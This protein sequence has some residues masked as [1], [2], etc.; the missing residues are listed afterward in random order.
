MDQNTKTSRNNGYSVLVGKHTGLCKNEYAFTL[1]AR[2]DLINH[3]IRFLVLK[4]FCC[5]KSVFTPE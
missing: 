3:S 2:R 1:S 4:G 5:P